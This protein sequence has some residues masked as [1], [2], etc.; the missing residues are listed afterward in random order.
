LETYK[1][2]NAAPLFCVSYREGPRN[3]ANK[4]ASDL[5]AELMGEGLLE[6]SGCGKSTDSG[7]KRPRLLRFVRQVIGVSIGEYRVLAILCN[8]DGK[9]IAEHHA[10]LEDNSDADIITIV[11]VIN[12][13]TALAQLTFSLNASNQKY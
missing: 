13:L 12:G 10:D 1:S 6:E 11:E 3:T 9:V 7:G 5:V 8:L 4:P 2:T